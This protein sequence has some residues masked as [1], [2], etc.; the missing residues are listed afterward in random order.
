L[1]IE[2]SARARN[3][4]ESETES[5]T[6]PER[7]T[8]AVVLLPRWQFYHS[9]LVQQQRLIESMRISS[10]RASEQV[11]LSYCCFLDEDC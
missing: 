11:S 4:M 9:I 3:E 2:A 10:M 5:E 8:E 6:E 1:E 7:T